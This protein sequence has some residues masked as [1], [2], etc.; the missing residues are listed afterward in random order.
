[1]RIKKETKKKKKKKRRWNDQNPFHFL[2]RTRSECCRQQQLQ[3]KKNIFFAN[4]LECM[5]NE[6]NQW[7][8]NRFPS[9]I[10]LG[11][12]RK[13]GKVF[14]E[15]SNENLIRRPGECA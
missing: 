3:T 8:N 4:N 13:K 15:E 11:W 9:P 1:L 5:L 6:T 12:L 10:E 7:K 14:L 2:S